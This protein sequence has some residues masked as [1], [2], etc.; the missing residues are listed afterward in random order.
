M[1]GAK[2]MTWILLRGLIREGRHWEDFP[3]RLR[4]RVQPAAVWTPDLPGNGR[5]SHLPSPTS[6]S[7][8]VQALRRSLY[9]QGARPPFR[10]VALS[11]GAM[12]T[13]EWMRH[14]PG[15]IAAAALIN[16]SSGRFS[17]PWHR[18]RPAI[19]GRLLRDVV[20]S[21]ET[22]AGEYAILDITSNLRS[23]DF[24]WQLARKWADYDHEFPVGTANTLRQLWAAI[25]FRAP[26]RPVSGVPT[27]IINGAGDR[28]VD[29]RCSEALSRAWSL[30]LR[31]HP[32]AG[33]DL[34]LD[35]PDWLLERLLEWFP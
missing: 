13:V 1:K 21:R 9:E 33:H 23:R 22:V 31:Q 30:P 17:P 24:L 15:E 3:D 18:L 29:H 14:W 20:F 28:L 11:L 10:V 26:A 4:Q 5:L 19:Y 2:S 16:T 6:V 27:L 12:V 25:R 34:P 35:A 8:M 7:G 32:E